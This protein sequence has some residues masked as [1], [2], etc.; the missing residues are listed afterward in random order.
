MPKKRKSKLDVINKKLDLILK[1]GKKQLEGQ[2]KVRRLEREQLEGQEDVEELEKK[3]LKE[4][5]DL[6]SQIKKGIGKH[7]LTRITIRDVFKGM[8]GAFIGI[9]SHFAF[10]KGT[11]LAANISNLTAASLYVISFIVG[12]I[13]LY[14]TGFRRVKQ[15]KVFSF[16][17]LRIVLLYV[18][19]L[20]TVVAVLTLFDQY[21]S[22]NELY[23]QVAVVSL[24]AIIGAG[25]AD[26]I[27]RE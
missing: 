22:L 26:L 27:G 12:A 9:I 20:A 16:L 13:L 23:K 24:P 19:A 25:A 4:L 17:P 5:D 15:V 10:K 2:K 6:E 8:I 18:V 1:R 3:Q 7:P 11:E 14:A 21:G